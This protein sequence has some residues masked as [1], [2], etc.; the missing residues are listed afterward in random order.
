MSRIFFDKEW[1][2]NAIGATF[3][4]VVGIILTFGVTLIIDNSNKEEMARKTVLITL[5]NIDV[6][7]HNIEED[8][9]RFKRDDSLFSAVYSYL[10]DRLDEMSE[11]SLFMFVNMLGTTNIMVAD[12]TAEKI[13]S[14]NF[15]VW[16][17][18]DDEK[19]IG[20]IANCFSGISFVNRISEEMK[21]EKAA[22]FRRYWEECPPMDYPNIEEA[23]LNLAMRNDL[24]LLCFNYK[25]R[26]YLMESLTDVLKDLN[27]R[28]KEV[29]DISQEE[30]D[31]LSNLLEEN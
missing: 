30:L 20:R 16:R 11:D 5:H 7:I 13:F 14:S 9:L 31:E 25:T 10:P 17:Y 1:W 27:R 12:Y 2:K 4:T 21:D 23:V 8:I 15:E 28:N 19:V 3:G 6:S 22:V 24:R 29:L 18:L 26:I